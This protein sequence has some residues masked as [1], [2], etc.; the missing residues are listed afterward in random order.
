MPPAPPQQQPQKVALQQ[1]PAPV[2]TGP[3]SVPD[4]EQKVEGGML[5]Y[6]DSVKKLSGVAFPPGKS[7]KQLTNHF[8]SLNCHTQAMLPFISRSADLLSREDSLSKE[9]VGELANL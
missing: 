9:E 3:R 4:T 2:Q 6:I 1:A 8:N 5:A 7:G